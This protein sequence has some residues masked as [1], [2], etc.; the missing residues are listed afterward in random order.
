MREK[1]KVYSPFSFY[2]HP[3]SRSFED[4]FFFL[5]LLILLVALL[6][7][8]PWQIFKFITLFTRAA[9]CSGEGIS[10]KLT[11]TFSHFALTSF[12]IISS[13]SFSSFFCF[14]SSS[15]FMPGLASVTL[16]EFLSFTLLGDR[17]PHRSVSVF[18]VLNFYFLV[19]WNS[20]FFLPTIPLVY[21]VIL[22]YVDACNCSWRLLLSYSHMS[23]FFLISFLFLNV[24]ANIP[25]NFLILPDTCQWFFTSFL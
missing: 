21:C 17:R 7:G 10:P 19:T 1:E 13:S 15:S 3:F 4:N 5:L 9:F 6:P 11:E 16:S 25:H 8:F 24:L 20:F 22:H 23:V 12:F 14:F 2:R 18:V